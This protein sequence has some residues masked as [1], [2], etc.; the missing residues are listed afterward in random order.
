[1][2]LF[3]MR[4]ADAEPA[5]RD[6]FFRRLSDKG[7]KQAEKMGIWLKNMKATPLRLAVSPYPR[8]YETASIVVGILG[9]ESELRADE[10][11][12]SGMTLDS[13]CAVVHE[14]GEPEIKLCLVG[15]THRTR[16]KMEE[17]FPMG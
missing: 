3:L 7:R 2:E 17:N 11:L 10:R 16:L 15:H 1:M 13:A 4:H 12:A 8:A 5:T 14:L 6:D 9:K